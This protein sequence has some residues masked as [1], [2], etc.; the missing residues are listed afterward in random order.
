MRYTVRLLFLMS[1]P[2]FASD[3]S[4]SKQVQSKQPNGKTIVLTCDAVRYRSG[5][6]GLTIEQ[7][8]SATPNNSKLEENTFQWKS[9][10]KQSGSMLMV[11]HAFRLTQP[12]TR[13]ELDV[14]LMFD[15]RYRNA[16]SG[17]SGWGDGDS[18][19]TNDVAHPMM[20][21]ISGFIQI[22]NDGR[23]RSLE[24]ANNKTY[25]HSRLRAFAWAAAYSTNFE[26]GPLSEASVG[27]VGR[28]PGTNGMTD[29]VVTPIGGFVMILLEDWLDTK[30]VKRYEASSTSI[31]KQ[32]LVRVLL[33]PDRAIANLLR[34]KAPWHRDGRPLTIAMPKVAP[35]ERTGGGT[36]AGPD[37]IAGRE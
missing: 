25:W 28:R 19:L 21:A 31:N 10:I 27:H 20:G 17:I 36:S 23:A 8:T 9:A 3:Y 37:T 33:N 15:S 24:F 14:P 32:R 13:Q 12:K 30:I 1:V 18:F 16:I 5:D 35:I 2:V 29:F 4:S 6:D 11:Q 7:R 26:L 34:R 22:Q